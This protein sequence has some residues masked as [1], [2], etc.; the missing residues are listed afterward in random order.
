MDIVAPAAPLGIVALLGQQLVGEPEDALQLV[1]VAAEHEHR[2]V[3]AVE[4]GGDL[5]PV[6]DPGAG[7]FGASDLET[8]DVAQS[9]EVLDRR[10]AVQSQRQ[11]LVGRRL[12]G[13]PGAQ[14]PVVLR[15]QL[16]EHLAGVADA[17][18]EQPVGVDLRVRGN[19]TKH[20]DLVLVLQW[21]PVHQ[22]HPLPAAGPQPAAGLVAELH[23]CPVARP[24]AGVA[25]LEEHVGDVAEAVHPVTQPV[26]ATTAVAVGDV[27]ERVRAGPRRHP[28]GVRR[29]QPVERLGEPVVGRAVGAGELFD[30]Q[31]LE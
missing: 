13:D 3:D 26:E 4:P 12:G 30:Q 24:R 21:R 23:L 17:E 9:V 22:L 19:V 25:R 31:V 11:Q 16:E 20:R 7:V 14:Q 8:L 27:H 15:E 28:Q 1:L 18:V 2:D 6:G 5:V 29:V 10:L